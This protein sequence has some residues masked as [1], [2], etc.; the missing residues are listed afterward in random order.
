MLDTPDASPPP[1]GAQVRLTP[2]RALFYP[3]A[4]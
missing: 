2:V 4:G 3:R 1:P